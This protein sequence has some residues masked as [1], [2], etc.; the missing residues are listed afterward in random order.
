MLEAWLVFE[1]VNLS[2]DAPAWAKAAAVVGVPAGMTLSLLLRRYRGQSWTRR[3]YVLVCGGLIGYALF[4]VPAV[5]HGI[6]A[7]VGA[8][9]VGFELVDRRRR[10]KIEPA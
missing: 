3:W 1:A 4:S 8:G 6:I 5:G 10:L 2:L 7:A 9:A